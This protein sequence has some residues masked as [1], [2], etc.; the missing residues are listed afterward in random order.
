MTAFSKDTRKPKWR[1]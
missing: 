1:F